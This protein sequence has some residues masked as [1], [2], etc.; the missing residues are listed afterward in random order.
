MTERIVIYGA[1]GLG[2]EILQVVRD[3]MECGR[4]VECAAF[5]VDKPFAN[6]DMVSGVPVHQ[7]FKALAEDETVRFVIAIGD[8][9]ARAR[10]AQLV[11]STIGPRFA[12]VVHPRALTG[13]S[14]SVGVGSMIMG[15]SSLTTGCR[16]GRHVLINPGCTVAHDNT[17]E[18]FAT[19]SPGVNL[20]GRVRVG[21]GCLLGVGANVAPDVNV[22]SWSVVG[23]GAC[24]IRDVAPNTVA[25]GVPAQTIATRQP[26]ERN[27]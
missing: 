13:T 22:G 14:V 21:E 25:V 18:D 19:L 7:N 12:T 20:A 5:V 4:A 15:L 9:A 1:G 6:A 3:M 27:P 8:P 10:I 23:A 16:L 24:V 17:I 2:R 26:G 11:E